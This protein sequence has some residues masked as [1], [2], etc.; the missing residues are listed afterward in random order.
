MQGL[1]FSQSIKDCPSLLGVAAAPVQ[2]GNQGLLLRK[3][4]FAFRNVTFGF[5][6]ALQEKSAIHVAP[7]TP[8]RPQSASRIGIGIAGR[9]CSYGDLVIWNASSSH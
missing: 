6:Q 2:F 8:N 9:S 3:V 5:N 1:Q 7:Y 4:P